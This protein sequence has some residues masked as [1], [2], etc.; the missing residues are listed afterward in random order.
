MVT[1]EQRPGEV[2]LPFDPAEIADNAN[3]I[4]L[5]KI[6]S[7]WRNR[8]D[9]PRNLMQ[10]RERGQ[11]AVIELDE[12][13]HDGLNGLHNQSRI[14]VLYWMHEA[15]RDL[16][17][18]TPR[19]KSESTG[20]FALRSP[21]RPNPI[22]LAAVNVVELNQAEG[23]IVID[24]IDCLDGTPVLDIKPWFNTIDSFAEN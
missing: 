2:A 23:K 7:P 5:G 15:R 8:S 21:V 16:I 1:A 9:C 22:A 13:W 20:V 19:H 17:I 24:A 6:R 12:V 18:Q 4:F 10:A 11:R 14:L 3:L